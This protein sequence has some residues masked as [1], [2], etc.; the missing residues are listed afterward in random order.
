VFKQKLLSIGFIGQASRQL[1]R[2]M[3]MVIDHAGN[4]YLAMAGNSLL[5]LPLANEIGSF[6]NRH[7]L[8]VFDRQG[9]IAN[10]APLWVNSDEPVN[11]G[12]YQVTG[13]R[14]A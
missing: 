13:E 5:S 4:H 10:D 14:R 9:C 1:E 12:D 6:P 7:K 8:A 2:G 3:Q 11:V